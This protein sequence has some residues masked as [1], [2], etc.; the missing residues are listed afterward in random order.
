MFLLQE[1]EGRAFYQS[2]W[3]M[4]AGLLGCQWKLMASQYQTGLKLTEVML[5]MP[6]NQRVNSEEAVETTP[7]RRDDFRKLEHRATERVRQGLAPPKEIYET[8]YRGR[9][10]WSRFPEWAR[11]SDPEVFEGCGHEG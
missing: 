10:D 2:W 7:K 6:V 8:P 4:A 9:I 3:Q 11:P 1:N 5:R